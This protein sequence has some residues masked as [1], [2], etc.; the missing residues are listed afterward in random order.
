MTASRTLLL[1]LACGGLSAADLF[2]STVQPL[3]M[4]RCAGC[5][6]TGSKFDFTSAEAFERTRVVVAGKP[7][8]SKLIQFV[9]AGIMPKS[10]QK[11]TPEE[12]GALRQWIT[13][14]RRLSK[15]ATGVLGVP[16]PGQA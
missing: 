9:S 10:G 12:I 13:R 3:L 8:E 4:S 14:G 15:A 1:I 11:L 2:E 6:G 16:E 7:D 5:H